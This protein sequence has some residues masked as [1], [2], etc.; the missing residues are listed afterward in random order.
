MTAAGDRE[1]TQWLRVS[2]DRD[3]A[4]QFV[5]EPWG[6]YWSMAPHAKYEVQLSGSDSI[7]M[8]EIVIADTEIKLFAGRQVWAAVFYEGKEISHARTSF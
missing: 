1:Q 3:T 5:L 8:P 4:I 7:D 6:E 2:N